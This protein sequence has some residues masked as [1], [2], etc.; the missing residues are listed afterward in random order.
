MTTQYLFRARIVHFPQACAIPSESVECFDDGAMVVQGN[1]IVALG[2]YSTIAP[3]YPQAQIKDH[4]GRWIVPGFIDSHLHYPQTEM[5]ACYGKQLLHWLESY[6]FPTEDKF[7]DPAY[8]AKISALFLQQLLK[9]GTTTGLVF[10]T[11]HPS[12]TD[13]LFTAASEL[14]MALIAGKVCMDRNCPPYLQDSASRAQRE[15]ADLIDKWHNNGRNRYALTPR[16]APTSTEQQ[17]A[18]LGEL[19]V[20]YQD[21]FIQTH[22]SENTD[23]IEWVKSLYPQCDGYLDVYD[24]YHMVRQRSVFGHCIHLTDNEWQRMGDSGATAAFCPTS[25]L[26]L[27][28]GL[29]NFAKARDNHVHV[30]L[31]TD[32]GAGTTFNM[33]KTYGE[34][35]KISQ[36]RHDPLSA[37]AGL[38]M[39]T[40]GPAVAYGLDHEIGNLNPGS[41]ADFVVLQPEFDELTSLRL[42][43]P[44]SAQDMLFALSMLGDDRAIY[45]TWIAG[46]CQYRQHKEVE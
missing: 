35:Y 15:S 28:S 43:H 12:A 18:A 26:F 11:V 41:H 16:F 9:N 37:L 8:S 3:R 30:A 19:A 21:V 17:M 27:G 25:N 32:V 34:G 10:G 23:E 46:V 14:N 29:F 38:Y 31:A 2:D 44:H 24:K 22:L 7:K 40:Q 1:T 20:Q 6:T 45:Q 13:T 36:L 5:I 42:T 39:M 4:R 33:L